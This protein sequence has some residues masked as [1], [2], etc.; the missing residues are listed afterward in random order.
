MSSSSSSSSLLSIPAADVLRLVQAH[1]LEAG[2]T[3]S[4]LALSQESGVGLAGSLQPPQNWI[5]H[6][7]SGNYG[8]V[9]E[10]LSLMDR[11][12]TRISNDLVAAVHEMAILEV[13]EAGDYQVATSMLRV[14]YSELQDSMVTVT[15][16]SDDSV[17]SISRARLLEQKLADLASRRS[18]HP[19][20]PVPTDW[21]YAGTKQQMR[22]ALGKRL[23]KSVPHQPTK[24][25]TT[26]LQ[27]AIQ[28]QAY[29]GELPQIK[30]WWDDDE[31][32]DEQD[33]EPAAQPSPPRKRKRKKLFDFVLGNVSVDPMSSVGG[34]ASTSNRLPG[35]LE[36]CVKDPY[37]VIKL[38]K[39]VTCGSAVFLP[40]L[41]GL[42]T[43]SSDGLIEIWDAAQDYSQLK[44]DLPY[45]REELM[46][47]QDAAVTAL[48][49]SNDCLM[50]ASGSAQGR[51]AVWRIDTGKC[52][53]T[54]VAHEASISSLAFS[55]DASHV[56]ASSS[57][58]LV[59]EFGL[60]TARM[61][62][63]FNGHGSYV[64]H[65]SYRLVGQQLLVVT[66][67]GDGMVRLYDSSSQEA[68]RILR[69]ISIGGSMTKTGALIVA[70][71]Q[72]VGAAGSTGIHTVLHLH[73]PASTMIFVPR[74]QRAF[75]VSYQ[76]L[77]MRTFEAAGV[78]DDKVFVAAALSPSNQLLYCTRE[79]GV[80]CIFAVQS[81]EMVETINDFGE[82]S[83]RAPNGSLT[84]PEISSMLSHP[85][86]NIIAAYSNDAGQ[87][88]G[89]IV[90]WK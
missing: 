18:K 46:L 70:D 56:L 7:E 2:L 51:I 8:V 26:L 13:A 57:N 68:L 37:S 31:D 81:G 66:A 86:K 63:E 48:V 80:C 30:Q 64:S 44:L 90:L 25:L 34:D 4:A 14:M 53:R 11:T 35:K 54:M 23:A 28:W 65:V 52:L 88:R 40:D 82:Q 9:L 67:G 59:R 74:G 89:Q 15:N 10:Q 21:Y 42:V 76:G 33:K 79:D 1:L 29:T 55:P 60:R 5:F 19:N 71:E 87:S 24:R 62:K 77:V 16:S 85:T 3:K 39:S 61:L 41:S 72:Q 75:L 27:Q 69:P 36:S 43:G 17:S 73:T 47:G 49:V 12:R 38:G 84:L 58:G 22:Q 50:L 32:E 6:C 45:Q 78:A 83:T 20:A